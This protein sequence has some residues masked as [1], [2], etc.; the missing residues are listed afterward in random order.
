MG[1]NFEFRQIEDY[2]DVSR[3]IDFISSKPL[4]YPNYNMWVE[5][6][7][8]ELLQGQK[9]SII[10]L[11]DNHLA[12]D[13]IYQP[14]KQIPGFLE[15]KNVRVSEEVR[16]RDFGHF[17][18]KQIEV[19]ARNSGNYSA[20]IVDARVSQRDIINLLTF[21]G[22]SPV[23]SISLYDSNEEDIIMIKSLTKENS[24]L[25]QLTKSFFD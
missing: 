15:I 5:K 24:G 17:M 2:R 20:L 25:I 14:H 11:F 21:S 18:L 7:E 19:E 1:F 22:F 6:T 3:I 8:Q 13:V 16:R 12:G 10:A 9:Q 4:N 23:T